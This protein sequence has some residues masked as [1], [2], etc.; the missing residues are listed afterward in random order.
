MSEQ[1]LVGENAA[2]ALKGK[3]LV[4]LW[5]DVLR[6]GKRL[7]VFRAD[8]DGKVLGTFGQLANEF[9]AGSPV[10][11]DAVEEA[12]FEKGKITSVKAEGY[13]K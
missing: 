6:H 5:D 12:L 13:D 7:Q 9:D 4:Y 8:I 2:L 10:F 1:E 3:L 11:S